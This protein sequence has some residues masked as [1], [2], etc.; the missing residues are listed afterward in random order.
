MA[1]R[2]LDDDH[3]LNSALWSL[4]QQE[5]PIRGD[6]GHPWLDFRP[7][8][9][10][11]GGHPISGLAEWHRDRLPGIGR[12]PD[13]D[14]DDRDASMVLQAA[15]SSAWIESNTTSVARAAALVSG[16][17]DADG[18][19]D[20]EIVNLHSVLARLA[21][22]GQVG[23]VTEQEIRSVHREQMHGLLPGSESGAYRRCQ[24]RVG[25][26]V[27]PAAADVPRL[28]DRLV[29]WLD[30]AFDGWQE[31]SPEGVAR[32]AVR[33]FMGHLAFEQIH[34]FVDGNG[35]MGRWLETRLMLQHPMIGFWDA[36]RGPVW[37]W[38]HQQRYYSALENAARKHDPGEFTRFCGERFDDMIDIGFR[39][40]PAPR[41]ETPPD[42]LDALDPGLM[43]TVGDGAVETRTATTPSSEDAPDRPEHVHMPET[44][45]KSLIA[46][47]MLSARKQPSA[48]TRGSVGQR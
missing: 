23:P 22:G 47:Y 32:A 18:S 4:R 45:A 3:V 40:A 37:C 38:D 12:G 17:V 15:L 28:M 9:W 35:R 39:P 29:G 48:D 6:L 25:V 7:A 13:S 1:P 36:F 44:A 30:R 16:T 11:N 26:Y 43:F 24:V 10:E 41:R 21:A 2:G 27:A 31:L 46:G 42:A 20:L 14:A 8:D 34:P 5:A 19:E 33:A